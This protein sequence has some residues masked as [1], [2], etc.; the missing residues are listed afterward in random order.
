[1]RAACPIPRPAI[2]PAPLLFYPN[3]R[4]C[5]QR[6][7]R[8]WILLGSAGDDTSGEL[9]LLTLAGLE[10]TGAD[11]VKAGDLVALTYE[12]GVQETYPAGFAKPLK[13]DIQGTEDNLVGFYLQII[14]DLFKEDE[15]L[16]DGIETLVFDLNEASNLS[17][18]ERSAVLYV[19]GLLYQVETREGTYEQLC[20]EGAIR[21]NGDSPLMAFEKGLLVAFSDMAFAS[22]DTFTFSVQKWR[23][24]LGAY[25][26][27]D[28]EAA[29]QGNEWSY[30]VG[31]T[32]IS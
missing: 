9:Y 23:S 30:T 3:R 28:C 21:Q 7:T 15:A 12:G 14:D 10:I 20:D 19:A 25:I 27:T 31:A 8:A 18:A 2:R 1:L 5:K 4:K 11:E 16:N 17:A 29:R 6:F 22:E 13:L 26:F 24:S 32:M